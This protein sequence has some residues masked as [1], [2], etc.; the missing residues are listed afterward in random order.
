MAKHRALSL[1]V[2]VLLGAGPTLAGAEAPHPRIWVTGADVPRLRALAGQ[3]A[4]PVGEGLAEVRRQADAF[5]AQE[6]LRYT[7]S[8]P[9]L[10]GGP[11]KEWSYTLS[12]EAPPRHDDYGHY[13]CWTELSRE[14]ETQIVTLSFAYLATGEARY[15]ERARQMVQHL[16]RWP[17]PW[18]DPSYGNSGA[19][20]DTAHL[21]GAVALFYD[22]CHEAL[23]E[24]ERAQLREALAQK[25]CVGLRQ[26]IPAYGVRYWPNGFAVL[27]AALG[28]SAVALQGEHPDAAGWL[29]E[30]LAYT[31]EFFDTQGKDG[32]CMEG[33][34][35]GTYG[36]DALARF[37]LALET[38]G[39]E[40][41]VARH[42]F[43]ET[44]PRYCISQMCPGDRR[45]TGFGDGW[46]SQPFPLCMTFLA[47]R[48]NRD[49]AWYLQEIGYT[50]PRTVEQIALLG[51][52]PE[53]FAD[54]RPPAWCPSQAFLDIGYAALRDGFNQKAAFLAFKCGPPTRE[55][56]HNHYDHNSFQIYYNGTWIATDPGYTGYFDPP[57]NKYGRCT[58]GHNTITLNVDD[59]YL[60]NMNFPLLGHDQVRLSSGR[61]VAFR[62]T[63]R[64]D[65][66]KGAAGSTYN[67][68]AEGASA[69]FHFWRAGQANGFNQADGPRPQGLRWKRYEFT[70]VAPAEAAEFCL[71]LQCALPEGSVW[72]DDAE[73]LVDG[74]RLKLP[75]PGFEEGLT[76]WMPRVVPGETGTHAVDQTTAHS[77]KQSARIDAPGGYYYWLPA[78][79]RLP[80][81]PGQR[82]TA[83]FW[84]RVTPA[85][86]QMERADR[87]ILFI[88]PHV[89]VVRDELAAPRPHSYGFVLHTLGSV[90]VTGSNQAVLAAPGAARL[91]THLYSPAGVQLRSGVFPGAEQRGPYLLGTTP[92]VKA[93]TFTSVLVAR[94]AAFRISN[95]GFEDGLAG[96][97]I[98]TSEN[99]KKNHVI[100]EAVPH[101]R[102][103]CGRIDSP[104]GYYY[105]PR[106]TVEPGNRVTVRF[107][108]KLE[109]KPSRWSTIYWWHQGRLDGN[110]TGQ[111]EGPEVAGNEW[112]QYEYSAT[113]P[114]GVEQACV[115][116]NYFGE[117]RAWYDD[118]AV[119]LEPAKP[120]MAPGEVIAPGAGERGVQ[121]VVDDLRHLVIFPRGPRQPE[122]AL[123]G[124]RVRCRD[125]VACVSLDAQGR[126][127]AAWSAN[128]APVFLDGK[129]VP[130]DPP[131]RG[132]R[133]VGKEAR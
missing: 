116:F 108:A 15:F 120:E 110:A 125:E 45:H 89:F 104:G 29:K 44:L 71:A 124:H 87:H 84:A 131:A 47:L 94:E 128:G 129:R 40:N 64:Y 9:G 91:E 75:N 38:A 69:C 133:A 90:T 23:S 46:F 111:A 6:R 119:T 118:V 51:L 12:D 22:W 59:D 26:A 8:M 76:H 60:A 123:G 121:V 96:W 34:G 37:L 27:A 103:R 33:P 4:S 92:K 93:T 54:P 62:S 13:P 16:C 107:W 81:R 36:A 109:G 77:G 130:L 57:D 28:L 56:G 41:P 101:S 58:F 86:P 30:A 78:G 50:R 122:V 35:Y 43:L 106:F 70:A 127:V 24:D 55:I 85:T 117:G 113:V 80:I 112:K 10:Q 114:A 17:I 1:C 97:V 11:A 100:D 99:A 68:P 95:G 19:C 3:P 5:L 63:P 72:Y 65:Y 52:R 88:K 73:V 79:K 7:T 132:K 32:G 2:T 98:R 102:R 39:G 21:G 67:A 18:T 82:I 115:A 83:R 105:T 31:R 61:I 20:L 49:A 74:R 126:P 42:P 53:R 25:A 66:V 14:I 48:G